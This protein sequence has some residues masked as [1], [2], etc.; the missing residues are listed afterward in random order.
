VGGVVAH[1]PTVLPAAIVQIP[2][3]HC[4]FAEQTSPPWVQND[5]GWH[6]PLLAHRP[7]Q[8][9]ALLEHVFP[10]LMHAT[11]LL[12]GAQVPPVQVWVQHS[13]FD[14]QALPLGVQTG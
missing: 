11:L 1:V 8:H 12:I 3:Q 5:E 4:A 6:V 13:P 9:W 2:V 7:E 10:R 14:A